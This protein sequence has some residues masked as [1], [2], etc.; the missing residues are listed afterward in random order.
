MTTCGLSVTARVWDCD[1]AHASGEAGCLRLGSARWRLG[2]HGT[3]D[4]LHCG[5]GAAAAHE[6]LQLGLL[7]RDCQTQ[8]LDC[9]LR[10]RRGP[11]VWAR[12]AD[13]A[14]RDL[15][16][17]PQGLLLLFEPALGPVK[18]L[19]HSRMLSREEVQL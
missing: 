7:P 4:A 3:L 11:Q 15:L 6:G 16:V 18:A 10:S 2:S 8:V 12:L 19:Q 13:S 14:L 17:E 9:C 5:L 1:E